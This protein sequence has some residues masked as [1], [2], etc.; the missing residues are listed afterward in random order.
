[1]NLLAIDTSTDIASVA[2]SVG[3]TIHSMEQE[4]VRQHAQNLL[5][6]IQSLMQEQQIN[7]SVLEGIVFDSGPGSFTGLRIACSIAKALAY[8]HDLPVFGISSMEAIAFQVRLHIHQ[9]EAGVLACGDAR[10]QEIY[11]AYYPPHTP[12]TCIGIQVSPVQAVEVLASHP[13]ILAGWGLEHYQDQ[14]PISLQ[15]KFVAQYAMVPKAE[16]L[17][18]MVQQGG[19]S[20]V[21]AE[22]A[23]PLYVRNQVTH[24]GGAHG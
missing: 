9:P 22:E 17:L 4:G 11:W 24:N 15:K 12:L 14:W 18:R 1:M 20:A 2:V 16:T 7:W 5:P 8:A 13:L 6:M 19:V 23:L 3:G 10:M 21:T